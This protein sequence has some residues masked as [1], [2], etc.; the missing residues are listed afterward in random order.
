MNQCTN[1]H[2]INAIYVYSFKFLLQFTCSFQPVYLIPLEITSTNSIF[3]E[4]DSYI[5]LLHNNIKN[6]HHILENNKHNMSQRFTG[7]SCKQL[8]LN[9]LL[10]TK[11]QG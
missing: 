7:W 9:Q 3:V 6:I 2:S 10:F 4:F 1:L 11:N 5:H 8:I